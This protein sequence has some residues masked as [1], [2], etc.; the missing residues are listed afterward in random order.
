M[1]TKHL[2]FM[3]EKSSLPAR[4]VNV[5]VAL[6]F[7]VTSTAYGVPGGIAPIDRIE[8]GKAAEAGS[9]K[10]AFIDPAKFL[11]PENFGSVTER[12][13]SSGTANSKKLIIQIQDSHCNYE[14]QTNIS[15]IID[16][17]SKDQA[18]NQC[19]N[20]IAVEGA[21]GPVNAEPLRKY[22]DADIK[23]EA[24]DYLMR[25]GWL[26]G[27]EF[28]EVNS[29][30][31]PVPLYGVEEKP[32][33]EE[34]LDLFRKVK[35]AGVKN[36]AFFEKLFSAIEILKRKVF[37]GSLAELVNM[38]DGWDKNEV[39]FTEYCKY[40]AAEALK[41]G[42]GEKGQPYFKD[43][44]YPNISAVMETIEI[45]SKMDKE[46][47][48]PQ[49]KSLIGA[50][51]KVMVKEE[52]SELVKQSLYLRI[53]KIT[54]SMFYE[55]LSGAAAANKIDM[56]KYPD[57]EK[58]VELVKL[59]GRVSSSALFEEVDSLEKQVKGKL[60]TDKIE[61]DLDNVIEQS[62]SLRNLMDLRM[63]RR[64]LSY[65]ENN[66][67]DI[68]PKNLIQRVAK[69]ADK[70]GLR[71]ALTG[72]LAWLEENKGLDISAS[73]GFYEVALKRDN[74]LVEKTIN[75]MERKKSKAVAM[76]AGGF[77]TEGMKKLFKAKGYS[78]VVV[79]PR[80]T[81]KYD[82]KIY[83]ERMLNEQSK[84]EKL[85]AQA[86]KRLAPW[87]GL[88]SN[89]RLVIGQFEAVAGSL[90]LENA[91][92]G[93]TRQAE[94]ING[95]IFFKKAARGVE[96]TVYLGNKEEGSGVIDVT[97][98]ADGKETPV[99]VKVAKEK[100]RAGEKKEAGKEKKEEEKPAEK[101]TTEMT[102]A[103]VNESGVMLGEYVKYTL[104]E[105][106]KGKLVLSFFERVKL[107]IAQVFG[108]GEA[109][110]TRKDLL[111]NKLR[112]LARGALSLKD[113][114]QIGNIEFVKDP[115]GIYPGEY[116]VYLN[117]GTVL[118][119]TLARSRTGA[120]YVAGSESVDITGEF[121]DVW[122]EIKEPLDYAQFKNLL[123]ER[124]G[125]YVASKMYVQTPDDVLM[126]GMREVVFSLGDKVQKIVVVENQEHKI[127]GLGTD[128]QR[129]AAAEISE[130]DK[131]MEDLRAELAG[132]NID[133][134]TT[135]AELDAL[136]RKVE[137]MEGQFAPG[138]APIELGLA[139]ANINFRRDKVVVEE[140]QAQAKAVEAKRSAEQKARADA[141]AEKARKAAEAQAAA[142]LSFEKERKLAAREKQKEQEKQEKERRDRFL[143]IVKKAGVTEPAVIKVLNERFLDF[144]KSAETE[145]PR[146]AYAGLGAT[147]EDKSMTID[148]YLE[149]LEKA[150]KED[151]IETV[152]A[153]LR[154]D[155]GALAS[156]KNY[157]E[158]GE[159]CLAAVRMHG[160]DSSA[161]LD[162]ALQ[163]VLAVNLT[164][165]LRG[166]DLQYQVALNKLRDSI[167]L[168]TQR[169]LVEGLGENTALKKKD[170]K[171]NKAILKFLEIQIQ[172]PRMT[173][174]E[175]FIQLG[176]LGLLKQLR[177]KD[178]K[179][180]LR[181]LIM[182]THSDRHRDANSAERAAYETLT[183]YLTS[184]LDM[185][186]DLPRF[187]AIAKITQNMAKGVVSQDSLKALV[188]AYLSNASQNDMK[189]KDI[190]KEFV[191]L[192][193]KDKNEQRWFIETIDRNLNEGMKRAGGGAAAAKMTARLFSD[194]LT[195]T[196][197]QYQTKLAK[198]ALAVP[199]QKDASRRTFIT[200]ENVDAIKRLLNDKFGSGELGSVEV[201]EGKFSIMVDGV[202]VPFK[203]ATDKDEDKMDKQDFVNV[204][205]VNGKLTGI[206]ISKRLM[207]PIMEAYNK[208]G[209]ERAR[210]MNALKIL[211]TS[212]EYV[213][214]IL[215]NELKGA[216][217]LTP[218][219]KH[220]FSAAVDAA[221]NKGGALNDL[222]FFTIKAMTVDELL[223][224]KPFHENDPNFEYYTAAMSELAS[225][226]A[227]ATAAQ[228]AQIIE[229]LG[230]MPL[231]TTGLR[232]WQ[233]S[234][235]YN[236]LL[237]TVKESK[238]RGLTDEF[239][240][241]VETAMGQTDNTNVRTVLAAVQAGL[242]A[243]KAK[244]ELDTLKDD[245]KNNR[246]DAVGPRIG[247][248]KSIAQQ[249]KE[250]E[251]ALETLTEKVA[252]SQNEAN[253]VVAMARADAAKIEVL[254]RIARDMTRRGNLG[255]QELINRF[256][257]MNQN[258]I[259]VSVEI[260]APGRMKYTLTKA[261][262]TK[263]IGEL[264]R[265]PDGSLML[266]GERIGMPEKKVA[267]LRRKKVSL[268]DDIKKKAPRAI[269]GEAHGAGP[270]EKRS[271]SPEMAKILLN[272]EAQSGTRVVFNLADEKGQARFRK[273]MEARLVLEDENVSEVESMIS[274]MIKR[275]KEHG[276][277]IAIDLDRGSDTGYRDKPG[278]VP[279]KG[280]SGVTEAGNKRICLTL[281][282]L[283]T[284][285]STVGMYDA[286]R[287][288][289]V[290][291]ASELSG[292]SHTRSVLEELDNVGMQ[293]LVL[294]L[295]IAGQGTGD[296]RFL[297]EIEA[298]TGTAINE[299]IEKRKNGEITKEEEATLMSLALSL[300]DMA[301]FMRLKVFLQN[302][303]M[304]S[305][306]YQKNEEVILT[307]LYEMEQIKNADG[308]KSFGRKLLEL[309][310]F[311]P[312]DGRKSALSITD[313]IINKKNTLYMMT[314][315]QADA[316]QAKRRENE[317]T[318]NA[319]MNQFF[320]EFNAE[321]DADVIK[322][323]EGIEEARKNGQ[324]ATIDTSALKKI[325]DARQLE[326]LMKVLDR[327]AELGMEMIIADATDELLESTAEMTPDKHKEM[328]KKYDAW[329]SKIKKRK[330]VTMLENTR[331]ELPKKVVAEMGRKGM[332]DEN[333]DINNVLFMASSE[334]LQD[335]AQ[336]IEGIGKLVSLLVS[337]ESGKLTRADKKILE[338]IGLGGVVEGGAELLEIMD[339][340][341]GT[342]ED[343]QSSAET[344][345]HA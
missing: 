15:K 334:A 320:G 307:L 135:T 24:S 283:R 220:A 300:R 120:V 318:L 51:Q 42:I 142:L 261:D 306:E 8:A 162:R 38:R 146:A 252:E 344:L 251:A 82:D 41:N 237:D 166:K 114:S 218:G 319:E 226:L 216:G 88:Q 143:S 280:L 199:G 183:F 279:V 5:L 9:I 297:H 84:F 147:V 100:V 316:K 112:R 110:T 66:K 45:E 48:G 299:I 326:M 265:N 44:R 291:E 80:M 161:G 20:L 35:L 137:E 250:D 67:E 89:R 179:K 228:R 312:S 286:F 108:V 335:Y 259:N 233:V 324:K 236:S 144:S 212:H 50:M 268:V 331:K 337:D 56:K 17:M 121:G 6:I 246:F 76:V 341:V 225:K 295:I 30:E 243:F 315:G 194:A 191:L 123:K 168:A 101:P 122:K 58:Y 273:F 7:T 134:I 255:E 87:L 227:G 25:I 132:E 192:L 294:D 103:D 93:E 49:R 343:M 129:Q 219:E 116:I 57:L 52:L 302:I 150:G 287:G 158:A 65:Y 61:R 172:D 139:K 31:T 22:P 314:E 140:V 180:M 95:T 27:T 240:T 119:M 209:E 205:V 64:D 21:E 336:L 272:K 54:S 330:K 86:G 70:E 3:A 282:Y 16:T 124:Y 325:K 305:P 210:A 186:D 322:M 104:T 148:A 37:T 141:L 145:L 60:F 55:Y 309:G 136:L 277:E 118:R 72:S 257:A 253:K 69:I 79:T 159:V 126:P 298:N 263:V 303:D 256:K 75:E 18:V 74:A 262:K 13:V 254:D 245:I 28:Y 274:E 115:S 317:I 40:V 164:G 98:D 34:N 130:R 26:T 202:E 29:K 4:V 339:I 10:P 188:N 190:R 231:G 321:T 167:N 156:N 203:V 170:K 301:A 81:K 215:I 266:S 174:Y 184:L 175:K 248:M 111:V 109:G 182:L 271:L 102:T 285:A 211:A 206:K 327:Y 39:K 249:V 198:A 238:D 342:F 197:L 23:E 19:L 62:K 242:K 176:K 125:E 33:Y 78:Y 293:R 200:K 281:E 2:K 328:T 85:F 68:T 63:S 195:D 90:A 332:I 154:A 53:G 284:A 151:V 308:I 289:A 204:D 275:G 149:M 193:S 247:R 296:M 171:F 269:G 345:I 292:N 36:N 333:G 229:K 46:K 77:H 189:A 304:K 157:K 97:K 221:M 165:D 196:L 232:V 155:V 94:I 258:Y 32:L 92:V 323:L 127:I 208:G 163:F 217:A 230:Q 128:L 178:G 181:T 11:V 290:H 267:S 276:A 329:K 117:D 241:A 83:L 131:Q 177:G 310:Y 222:A 71:D 153:V 14:S 99:V 105:K 223:N 59:H 106:M 187:V 340:G 201:R 239:R 185:R 338:Q 270:N 152:D 173:D 313:Q 264:I 138:K 133:S 207:D 1:K 234:G 214:N 224:I 107:W 91:R 213:E 288:L 311:M 235:I 113:F 12:F 260:T 160:I 278:M 169:K 96:F 244:L 73:R 43:P 47:I